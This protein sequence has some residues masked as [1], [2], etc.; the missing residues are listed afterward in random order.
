MVAVEDEGATRRCIDVRVA[1]AGP[2]TNHP[3]FTEDWSKLFQPAKIDR[4]LKLYVNIRMRVTVLFGRDALRVT[5]SKN[6]GLRNGL[7]IRG[8]F[9]GCNISVKRR[10]LH[11]SQAMLPDSQHLVR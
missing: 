1:P 5:R 11:N 4:P 9:V 6:L 7:E 2:L 8:F 3:R 10:E